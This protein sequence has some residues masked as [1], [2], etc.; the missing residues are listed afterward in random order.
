M[1]HGYNRLGLFALVMSVR[2]EAWKVGSFVHFRNHGFTGR[3]LLNSLI[4][5]CCMAVSSYSLFVLQN[6]EEYCKEVKAIKK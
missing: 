1:E 4:R 6:K 3:Y 2:S 5:S